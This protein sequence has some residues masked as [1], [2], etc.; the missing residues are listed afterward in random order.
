MEI[1]R[2][3][4]HFLHIKSL[5]PLLLSNEKQFF[6]PFFG[7]LHTKIILCF[8]FAGFNYILNNKLTFSAIETANNK[9]SQRL[10]LSPNI[11]IPYCARYASSCALSAS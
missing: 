1:Q 5:F 3:H 7:I 6:L 11:K 8:S 2:L 9:D 4:E 10:S